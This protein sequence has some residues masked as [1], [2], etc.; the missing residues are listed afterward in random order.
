MK[1]ISVDMMREVERQADTAGIT[2][3][4]MMQRAGRGLAVRVEEIY[5][6]T[7]VKNVLGLVGPGNNGGDVLVALSSLSKMGWGVRAFLSQPR[8]I[9]DPLM[10][11]LQKSGI[12]VDVFS[13]DFST[14][15]QGLEEATVLL[16]GLL[17]T[18]FK[19]PLKPNLAE[20]L[21]HI[22]SKAFLPHIVA[23]DCPSGVDCD[24]GEVADEVLPAEVTICM[25][26]V[27]TGLVRFPAFENVG[28]LEVVDLGFSDDLPAWEKIKDEVVSEDQAARW[29][30]TRPRGS[31]KGTYGTAVL[32]VGSIN[33][34]G[35]A[36]LSGRAALKAGTGLVRMA[37]PG[38]L[39]TALAGHLPEA[40]WV[41]LPAEMGVISTGAVEVLAD[42]LK[43]VNSLLLGCGWGRETTTGEFIKN[44]LFDE[45]VRSPKHS[46]GF[47]SPAHEITQPVKAKLPPMV[48][49]AD[50]LRLLSKVE[51]WKS[52]LSSDVILTPHPG[53]LADLAGLTV[54]EIQANRIEI[55]RKCAIE[56]G[57]I[58]VLKGANTVIAEPGGTIRLIPIA[59]SALAHAGTGDVLAGL[60]TGFLAQ[61]LSPFNAASLG[62]WVHGKAGLLAEQWQGNPA[63]VTATDVIDAI[64]DVF[65]DFGSY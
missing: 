44:L 42:E 6:S 64:G 2:Y 4:E 58:L 9:D 27:K 41:L 46:I 40:T 19:Q 52:L 36:L 12:R 62:C 16:D 38:S 18:G 39:H 60:I 35:A 26:A 45:T 33:Y 43:N 50:G 15:D 21:G 11:D 32:A 47:I 28:Q 22:R 10:Q 65:Q 59:T 54:D 24:S 61:G 57:V 30:P 51:G 48:I 34:T 13:D 20:I 25:A 1:L 8:P 37:I 5:G 55:A 49:D 53:E 7:E 31:H 29:L 3:A 23:V 63:S 56:W 17:G 14:M